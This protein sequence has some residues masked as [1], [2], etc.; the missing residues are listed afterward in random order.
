VKNKIALILLVSLF[1]SVVGSSL[2]AFLHEP[3]PLIPLGDPI[4]TCSPRATQATTQFWAIFHA[5]DYCQVDVALAGL[6]A[7]HQENPNDQTVTLLLGICHL[8]KFEER[9]R[10]QTPDPAITQH[11]FLGLRLCERARELDPNHRLIPGFI[12]QASWL[13]GIVQSDPA[14]LEQTYCDLLQNTKAYPQF[15]GFLQGWVLSAMLSE[16]DPRYPKAIDGYQATI[17]SCIGFPAP[18]NF[19]IAGP[20][21]YSILAKRG[22]KHTVCYN[23]C[24]APHNL[25]GT[26]LGFGDAY[27]KQGKIKQAR[28]A[29]ES[30]KRAPSYPSWQYK[31]LLEARLGN[32]PTLKLKFRAETGQLD[33]TEPAMSFQSC[34]ACAVCHAR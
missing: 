7:A 8:W 13:A 17:D 15:H 1:V 10:A 6:C 5:A 29:Y 33:V 4:S 3:P 19:P 28:I 9:G 12:A 18:R 21:V 27:L 34:F 14:R 2:G 11:L 22:Q 24:V 26:F 16:C 23:T 25:E 31:D 20:V 32:L 30:V